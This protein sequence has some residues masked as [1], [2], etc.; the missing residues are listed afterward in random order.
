MSN[1]EDDTILGLKKDIRKWIDNNTSLEISMRKFRQRTNDFKNKVMEAIETITNDMLKLDE[2]IKAL[3]KQP[4]KT[5][6]IHRDGL[7]A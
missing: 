4:K 7:G 3:E 2:R 6:I 1:L 5:Y